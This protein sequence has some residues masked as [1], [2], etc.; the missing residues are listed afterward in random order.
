MDMREEPIRT[1]TAENVEEF[2]VW[3]FDSKNLVVSVLPVQAPWCA[4]SENYEINQ[5]P[6]Q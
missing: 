4:S 3:V 2:D 1:M 6:A 5:S